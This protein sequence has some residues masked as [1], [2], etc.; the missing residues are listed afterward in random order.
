MERTTAQAACD[1]RPRSNSSGV[2]RIQT[3]MPQPSIGR[4]GRSHKPPNLDCERLAATLVCSH[5]PRPTAR[6]AG[7][8]RGSNRISAAHAWRLSGR[9]SPFSHIRRRRGYQDR[10]GLRITAQ[11]QPECVG[12]DWFRSI[13]YAGACVCG[14]SCSSRR[15]GGP[16]AG[17]AP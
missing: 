5:P 10:R 1:F 15:A 13:S 12:A 8:C 7:C 9:Q 17:V 4:G 16:G 14:P 3:G 6:T 11:A 2:R